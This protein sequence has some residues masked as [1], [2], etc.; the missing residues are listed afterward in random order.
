MSL[1]FSRDCE[2]V[3]EVEQMNVTT[4]KG[5]NFDTQLR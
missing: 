4:M 3:V 2:K 1:A 5:V